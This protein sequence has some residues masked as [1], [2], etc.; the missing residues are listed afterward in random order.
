MACL[1][2]NEPASYSVSAR[3]SGAK[4][5]SRSESE[6]EQG[7]SRHGVDPKPGE[8]PMA[9]VKARNPDWRPEPVSVAKGRD[10][11]WVGVKCQANPEIAGSPRNAFRCSLGTQRRGGRARI[12]EGAMAYRTRTKRTNA[13]GDRPGSETVGAKLH[14]RE[15]NSPDRQLRSP[16]RGLVGK[17]GCGRPD[18]Q[19]V[20]LEAAI[21]ERVRNS[22]LV[23]VPR[24][25]NVP[26]LS[27]RRSRGCES[28]FGT[29]RGRGA[30]SVSR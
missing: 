6:S 26:G 1:L 3:L 30:F 25:D 16:S 28:S 10:E 29:G 19:E 2:K 4:P 7:A 8:L 21:L 20:G 18:S 9:R 12:G 27:Q 5:R 24:A 14:R 17:G 15:G 23:D 22:S 13:R 11:L